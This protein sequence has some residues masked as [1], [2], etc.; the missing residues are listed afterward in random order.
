MS[1]PGPNSAT[2]S[3]QQQGRLAEIVAR[4]EHDWQ[5]GR[6]RPLQDY[7][8]DEPVLRAAVLRELVRAE[9]EFRLEA[10]EPA[11]VEMYLERYPELVEQT[12]FLVNLL[13]REY[14]LRQRQESGI[15]AA[16][17]LDR[18]P[19][20]REQLAARLQIGAGA[21]NPG[22]TTGGWQ[23]RYES[24]SSGAAEAALPD[25]PGYEVLGELG[26]GGMGVVYK[27]RQLGLN[28][29]VALKMLRSQ[30]G[31]VPSDSVLAR[32]RTEAEAVAK[33]KHPH[34]V[35]VYAFGEHR[36]RPYFALEFI[37]GTTLAGRLKG[38]PWP[39]RQAAALVATLAGATHYA[40]RQGILHRDLKPANILL[41]AQGQPHIT[42]FGLARDLHGC[43]LT[44]EGAVLGTPAYMAPEQA[45]GRTGELSP[46][47]DVFGLGAILY[48]LLTGR[49]V[50]QGPDRTAVVQQACRGAVTP[51]L[52]VNPGVPRSLAAICMKALAAGHKQR[53]GSA[54]V[55]EQ[56]LRRY[57]GRPRRLAVAG[58][59]AGLL[60][61]AVLVVALVWGSAG[62]PGGPSNRETPAGPAALTGDLNVRIWTP[63]GKGKR[64]WKVQEM[65]RGAVPVRNG[66][67]VHL[68]ARLNQPAHVYL[69]WV[70]SQGQPTP[71]YPWNRGT[72]LEVLDLAVP[73]PEVPAERV[74]DSPTQFER[75]WPMEGPSGL[76]TILLLAR[77]EPLDVKLADVLGKLKPAPFDNPREVVVRG[78]DRDACSRTSTSSGRCGSLM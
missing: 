36:G 52:R 76:E 53:Q 77:R 48:H 31:G 59:L 34:I 73:P 32:F 16:D 44:S 67:W 33:L 30:P 41:D 71:M 11:R 63:G 55:L 26:R 47:T 7:L 3:T 58:G 51:P 35:P 57:L 60:V 4:F 65:D 29:T 78:F 54:A 14:R 38:P 70:D 12:T 22:Q 8:P 15:A 18:F 49:P 43:G 42:D 64:G 10:R 62:T 72:E 5:Q 27:A 69:L 25:I 39:P 61:L 21:S 56:E 17:Y 40:H 1:S 24:A 37:E 75:G 50:Y 23:R 68:E 6:R 45:A 74:V 19:Q 66:E 20:Y 2:L 28:R 13:V 46:A 9:L